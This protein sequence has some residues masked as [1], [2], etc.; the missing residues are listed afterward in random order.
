MKSLSH[1]VRWV[2]TKILHWV[3]LKSS[4]VQAEVVSMYRCTCPQLSGL[5]CLLGGTVTRPGQTEP[6]RH[7]VELTRDQDILSYSLISNGTLYL[8]M[9]QKYPLLHCHHYFYKTAPLFLACFLPTSYK[10]LGQIIPK[11]IIVVIKL[12]TVLLYWISAAGA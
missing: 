11:Y 4:L 10:T 9:I 3:V 12:A 5:C 1:I 6:I 2:T 8:L 7:I